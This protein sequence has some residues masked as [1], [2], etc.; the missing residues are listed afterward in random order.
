MPLLFLAVRHSQRKKKK[1]REKSEKEARKQKKKKR[2]HA[3]IRAW[4]LG[5]VRV[6]NP[7]DAMPLSFSL[8]LPGRCN[9]FCTLFLRH[10]ELEPRPA[11]RNRPPLFSLVTAPW[12]PGPVG[13][14][15]WVAATLGVMHG[16]LVLTDFTEFHVVCDRR[17]TYLVRLAAASCL[18]AG[19]RRPFY[20][21]STFSRLALLFLASQFASDSL[22]RPCASFTRQSAI[23]FLLKKKISAIL[24]AHNP[25][26]PLYQPASHQVS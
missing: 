11:S 24:P 21:L 13:G 5:C 6:G 8:P 10:A 22:S 26:P 12:F 1:K 18:P 4:L 15:D 2:I 19:S 3:A 9:H 23:T 20:S 14:V 17:T 25:R 7:S 16:A